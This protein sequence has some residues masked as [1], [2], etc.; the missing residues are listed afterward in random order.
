MSQLNDP[1]FVKR[2][3]PKGM[4]DLTVAFPDQCDEAIA[5]SKA[6]K[7]VK[8]LS[9]PNLAI[10]TGLGGSAAGGDFVRA[11]FEEQGSCGFFVN[12]DYSLPTFVNEETLIF[13][14]SYSGNTEETLAAYH[15]A[16][17]KNASIVA[18][19]SG[20]Q[21]AE[22]ARDD[23]YPLIIVPGGRPPRT[24]LAYLAL[25]VVVVAEEMGLIPAQD[26]AGL[27]DCLRKCSRLWSVDVPLEQ[28]P[29]KVLATK[30]QGLVSVL[31]GLGSW[32]GLVASR[33]KSQ[34]NE[35]AKCMTFAN[36]FPELCHNEILGWVKADEQGVKQWLTIVLQDGS[37][38]AKMKK[39]AEVVARLTANVTKTETVTAVGNDLLQKMLSLAFF[40]DFV[41]IY[42]AALNGVDPEN[43]DSINTLKA[44]L[45]KVP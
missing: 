25:P 11:L 10:L 26:Y 16:K 36:T 45:S 22:M 32:Q 17:K 13:A 9:R 1:S 30:M 28:N 37:E 34:I 15:D 40:G 14:V 19:T 6:A 2:L 41:S 29:P 43:I 24:A 12:R 42:L 18:I 4:Y 3:D 35:N 39:R 7:M 38:S 31:Y 23:G 21:L 27:L 33:W 44:E 20:G 8:P 5:L